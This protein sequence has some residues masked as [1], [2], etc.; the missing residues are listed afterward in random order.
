MSAHPALLHTEQ[1][2]GDRVRVAVLVVDGAEQGMRSELTRTLARRCEL[3]ETT[4]V[5]SL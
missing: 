1:A 2:D 4:A 3:V 5:D